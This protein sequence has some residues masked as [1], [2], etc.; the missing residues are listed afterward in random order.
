MRIVVLAIALAMTLVLVGSAPA[1][2]FDRSESESCAGCHFNPF[3]A[4][5]VDQWLGTHKALSYHGYGANTYCSKCH[6]PRQADAAATRHDNDPVAF[7]D[8]EAITC[9]GC[10]PHHGQCDPGPRIGYFDP[11]LGDNV[12]LEETNELC[13]NCHRGSHHA[14][15]TF[16]AFGKVMFE[17]KGVTCVDCHMP[18]VPMEADG[19]I[20][21]KHSHTFDVEDG[22]PYSCGTL[23]G[24]CHENH[25][26]DW[27]QKQID[28]GLI[29]GE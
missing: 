18:K 6:S 1:N 29:H 5:I 11:E 3:M 12:C 23:P 16:G 27:A 10:H 26:A 15:K 20:L 2:A 24:G 4:V 13:Q 17:K 28:K 9:A 8:F 19:E 14:A 7:E 25:T 21:M 22:L